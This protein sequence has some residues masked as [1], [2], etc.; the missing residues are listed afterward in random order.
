[1]DFEFLNFLNLDKVKSLVRKCSLILKFL[2]LPS[3]STAVFGNLFNTSC[4]KNPKV[5]FTELTLSVDGYTF[6]SLIPHVGERLFNIKPSTSSIDSKK[7]LENKSISS[8]TSTPLTG[9]I[10]LKFLPTSTIL[11]GSL[12]TPRPTSISGHT[13]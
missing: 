1:M 6:T 5:F 13:V 7:D 9:Y 10:S 2:N 12:G 8:V 3:S 4:P 11:T